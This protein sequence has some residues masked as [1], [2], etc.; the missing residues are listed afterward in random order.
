LALIRTPG[1]TRPLLTTC[2]RPRN[3]PGGRLPSHLSSMNFRL[4]CSGP[5]HQAQDRLL[6]TS[7]PTTAKPAP[8]RQHAIPTLHFNGSTGR[9]P[10]LSQEKISSRFPLSSQLINHKV[11]HSSYSLRLHV[12]TL[13]R[14]PMS[15][16]RHAV[17][18]LAHA[19]Q[20]TIPLN[21]KSTQSPS[22]IGVPLTRP[23]QY[24]W[25]CIDVRPLHERW[26]SLSAWA[27]A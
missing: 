22:A 13:S 1:A 12:C 23:V 11:R 8:D 9:S 21:Q 7:S 3:F 4:R 14:N 20:M 25:E 6:P 16:D 10:S 26:T 24:L 27:F 19:A 17:I 15:G 18:A 5:Y 2:F